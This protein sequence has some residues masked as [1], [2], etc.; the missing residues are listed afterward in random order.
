MWSQ[1]I[2]SPLHPAVVHFPM[3]LA[4]I[5]PLVAVGGFVAMRRGVSARWAWGT[6]VA[7]LAALAL[8]SFVAKQTG[9]TDEEIVEDVVSGT[10]MERHEEAADRFMVLS[11]V[12]L[13]MG[14]AGLSS[15]AIGRIGRVATIVGT[16]GLVAAG[17]QVGHEGGRLVY[18][19]GAAAAHVTGAPDG[20]PAMIEDDDD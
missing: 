20:S 7:L 11:L 3:A 5:A 17:W 14:V 1:L 2:P 13:A 12:V 8:S 4:V 9:E 18:Q 19:E 6:V 10:A 16:V 15:G